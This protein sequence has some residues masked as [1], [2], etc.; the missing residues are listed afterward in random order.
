M[1]IEYVDVI[2]PQPLQRLVERREQV[3]AAPPLAVWPR[4]HP[5]AGL[6]RDNKFVAVASEVLFQYTAYPPFRCTGG[7][8]IVIGKVEMSDA[9]VER[10]EEHGFR[11]LMKRRL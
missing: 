11:I 10:G 6:R 2:E 5:V 3:F 1:R 8:A 7:R 9:V 4:P